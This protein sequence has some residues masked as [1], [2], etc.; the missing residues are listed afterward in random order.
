[1]LKRY[2]LTSFAVVAVVLAITGPVAAQIDI[3]GS[4]LSGRQ[5]VPPIFSE[6]H[7]FLL[8][9]LHEDEN[10]AEWSLVYFGT[11]SAVQQAHIHFGTPGVNGA[12]M[13]FLCSNQLPAPA[14]VVPCPNGPGFNSVSGVITADD[15]GAA[16][17]AQGV[18]AGNFSAFHEALIEGAAYV[19]VHTANFPGGEIRGSIDH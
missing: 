7:G 16:A 14:G 13:V 11:S 4:H 17:A 12:I 19:N 18:N 15:V 9:T 8:I 10:R 2:L 5:E 6:A 3:F 1:M